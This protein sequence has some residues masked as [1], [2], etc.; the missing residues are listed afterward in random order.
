MKSITTKAYDDALGQIYSKKPKENFILVEFDYQT[1]LLLPYDEGLKFLSCLKHAEL[2][3][4]KYS[5]P[6]VILPFSADNFKTKILSRQDYENIKIA[7][8][9]GVTVQELLERNEQPMPI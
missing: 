8:L 4:E 1:S 6:K 7:A 2:Y 5:Q 3:Q 9:L